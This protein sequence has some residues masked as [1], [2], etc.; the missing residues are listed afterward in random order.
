MM[1][2]V[3][4]ILPVPLRMP[5][6]PPDSTETTWM[7]WSSLTYFTFAQGA[8]SRL[9]FC[10]TASSLRRDACKLA[11]ITRIHAGTNKLVWLR[12]FCDVISRACRGQL[13]TNGNAQT[14]YSQVH[15]SQACD[16]TFRVIY[17]LFTEYVRSTK[18]SRSRGRAI[19]QTGYVPM[20][21]CIYFPCTNY[22]L[23]FLFYLRAW[24]ESANIIRYSVRTGV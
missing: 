24:P 4:V 3:G 11:W 17:T 16:P 9:H 8:S 14:S 19:D 1:W 7:R 22:N 21:G 18:Y 23:I 12:F 2:Q 6:N 10:K 20:P 5:T 13:T 15:K